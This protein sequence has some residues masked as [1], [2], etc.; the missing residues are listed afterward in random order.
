MSRPPISRSVAASSARKR[1]RP[2]R[3]LRTRQDAPEAGAASVGMKAAWPVEAG[4]V[5]EPNTEK[6]THSGKCRMSPSWPSARSS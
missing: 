6:S 3:V 5:F 4:S 1:R 2:R